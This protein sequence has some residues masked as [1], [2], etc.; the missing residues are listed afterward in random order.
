MLK[1]LGVL[2]VVL[3]L[4]SCSDK[5]SQKAAHR[6]VLDTPIEVMSAAGVV[7][8]VIQP[9]V[10][11]NDESAEPVSPAVV[12]QETR[13]KQAWTE[14]GFTPDHLMTQLMGP[15]ICSLGE[16][17][18][19]GC[20]FAARVMSEIVDGED[21]ILVVDGQMNPMF[22]G[23]KIRNIGWFA[24]HKK[25]ELPQLL[26]S[27]I[28]G[29]SERTRASIVFFQ[30][31]VDLLRE[32]YQKQLSQHQDVTYAVQIF[33]DNYVEAYQR[34]RSANPSQDSTGYH[35]AREDY[36]AV[37]PLLDMAVTRLASMDSYNAYLSLAM[38]AF[39]SLPEADRALKAASIYNEYSR[40]SADGHA[41]L[42]LDPRVESAI[43]A[44]VEQEA[45]YGIGA[46]VNEDE[47]DAR[48]VYLNPRDNSAALR[49]GVQPNDRLVSVGGV[50]PEG[51]SHAVQLI[52]GPR[53]SEVTLVVERWES[54]QLE[55]LV[56]PRQ[57]IPVK[58]FETSQKT[59][60]GK[61]YGVLKVNTFS[62]TTTPLEFRGYVKNNDA[63]VDGW[64]LDLR[65][66]P[67]GRLTFAVDMLS[68]FLPK[69]SPTVGQ[70]LDNN[71]DVMDPQSLL[72]TIEDP[73]TTKKMIVLVDEGSASASEIVS[74]VLQEYQRA[75]IIG[76]RT[77]G[78]GSVQTLGQEDHPELP[79]YPFW[80]RFTKIT[81]KKTTGRYFFPSGRTPEWVGVEPDVSVMSNPDVPELY[82]PRE[83]ESVPFSLG[84]IGELW[85]QSRPQLVKSVQ[86]CVAD[87]GVETK[88]WSSEEASKP[89]SADYQLFYSLDAL[90][91]F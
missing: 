43:L 72:Q 48:L 45:Q 87:T 7:L 83:A 24:V 31:T 61:K 91:C 10:L 14:S 22:V 78:K 80:S 5:K 33:R 25:T 15:E 13:F 26:R 51:V 58:N 89:F 66:N 17:Q 18:F 47:T 11:A 19:V 85:V 60:N 53:D 57:P 21:T 75:L 63:D 67:G 46:F 59:V 28:A 65:G 40:N 62:D 42:M 2:G 8:H 52:K 41:G 88:K 29:R 3:V 9:D 32:L 84:S 82:A 49:F 38:Q 69:N 74:G 55:T 54:K 76:H 56:I 4:I 68:V 34:L 1:A 12:D 86:D 70:S 36:L 39:S 20:F 50:A 35:A 30:Q 90:N 77:F 27:D 79:G 44:E 71:V 64:V 23:E 37:F 73:V 81:Y 16:K 6:G